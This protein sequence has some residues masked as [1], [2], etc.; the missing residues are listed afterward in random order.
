MSHRL[1]I[2]IA[3][4]QFP[5]PRPA[6]IFNVMAHIIVDGQKDPLQ[7]ITYHWADNMLECMA[8]VYER[9]QRSGYVVEGD[10]PGFHVLRVRHDEPVSQQHLLHG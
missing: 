9:L 8:G 6:H 3:P 1:P 2:A 4:Q 5:G 10:E 7:H